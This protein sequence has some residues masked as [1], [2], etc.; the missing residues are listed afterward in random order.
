MGG[1]GGRAISSL[2]LGGKDVA[3]GVG[4]KDV[5]WRLPGAHPHVIFFC[6]CHRLFSANCRLKAQLTFSV[7]V[8]F[9]FSPPLLPSS[10][11]PPLF[12]PLCRR[13]AVPQRALRPAA[14]HISCPSNLQKS[15]GVSPTA[16]R[17][18][19]MRARTPP[20]PFHT[21]TR[22]TSTGCLAP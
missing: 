19:H 6:L 17:R 9:H 5:K 16:T 20:P 22:S 4:G 2:P 8:P 12:P 11:L 13:V 15:T 3:D 1:V 10:C 21:R 18:Q 7:A 14:V